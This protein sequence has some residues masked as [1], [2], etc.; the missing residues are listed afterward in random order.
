[1]L[2]L[3]K[4]AP[5]NSWWRRLWPSGFSTFLFRLY[6][7]LD[8]W[9]V[10]R[11]R[12]SPDAFTLVNL[13]DSFPDSLLGGI[14]TVDI[15][16]LA[17]PLTDGEPREITGLD[18]IVDLVPGGAAKGLSR[19]PRYGV[20]A[21]QFGERPVYREGPPLFWEMYEGNPVSASALQIFTERGGRPHTIYRSFSTTNFTSLYWNRNRTFWKTAE[22]VARRLRDLHRYGWDYIR[23]L[24]TFEETGRTSEA[25]YGTPGNAAMVRFLTRG[26]LNQLRQ[27]IRSFFVREQWALAIRKHDGSSPGGKAEGFRLLIPP[28]D[29]FYADPFLLKHNDRNYLFFEDYPHR[30]RK[31]LIA[32]LEIDS[33]GRCG[34]PR[35][36]LERDYH[37]SYPFV[38]TW[39]GQ[40]YL[41]P[42][43]SDRRTVELYRA[44][45]F[46]DRWELHRVLME[47]IR[48]L[49]VTLAWHRGKGWLFAC[50]PVEGK[51]C[52]ELHVFSAD[53]PLGPWRPHPH[54]PVVSDVRRARP[55]GRLF[56]VH[57]QLFRPAQDC[58]GRYGQAIVLNRV[59]ELS[60]SDYREVPVR[61][62]DA[63]WV[64][65]GLATHTFNHNEEF[66][67]LD[68]QIRAARRRVASQTRL[69]DRH[70]SVW[71]PSGEDGAYKVISPLDAAMALFPSS[72]SE[73]TGAAV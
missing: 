7:G 2:I 28:A 18:L 32:C 13:R 56:T 22:F 62:I 69:P 6:E 16:A 8:H 70:R 39:E 34:E 20:W 50:V 42:E 3:A 63:S 71:H 46:P 26:F 37:L 57:G 31:G 30:T 43:T 27:R 58:S 61:R 41:I 36:V 54:N 51:L 4:E 73:R 68:V 45:R 10:K 15:G 11:L 40:I 35:V 65:G 5:R 17:G 53:S 19:W 67:V 33:Q 21:L 72:E 44:T 9:L 55:A 66:E 38:F 12:R 59:E 49:D 47:N 23:S 1:V 64:P 25:P 60:E 24:D 52:D 14:E 48:A 29:R